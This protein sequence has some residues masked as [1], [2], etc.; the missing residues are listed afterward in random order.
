MQIG[1]IVCNIPT[2]TPTGEP[3]SVSRSARNHPLTH[4]YAPSVPRRS[5]QPNARTTSPMRNGTSDRA[6]TSMRQALL[7]V[8]TM[9]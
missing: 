6:R 5:V 1:T 8:L 3:I 9:K 7:R 4:P 2:K